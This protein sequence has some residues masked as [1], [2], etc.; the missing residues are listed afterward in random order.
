MK[1]AMIAALAQ[2]RVIGNNNQLP[3]RLPNDLKYFKATTM[4]KPVIM[5]R[6]TF[7]SIGKPLP[8]RSNIVLSNKKDFCPPGVEVA[9]STEGALTL[10]KK[11]ALHNIVDELMVIGGEQLYNRFL[12]YS[13]R[14]YLTLIHADVEGDAYFP[15]LDHSQWKEL[16]REDFA[17]SGDN[18][19]DYS[20]VVLSHM[21]R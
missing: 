19:Y 10:A 18:P 21:H 13:D 2:N 6:K 17:A 5:G 8:G 3:W 16:S 12:P 20:F 15:L 9:H 14:L 7:E 11:A 1:L 4:G